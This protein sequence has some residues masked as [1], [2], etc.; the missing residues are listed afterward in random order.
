MWTWRLQNQGWGLAAYVKFNFPHCAR[1]VTIL[2]PPKTSAPHRP[3]RRD[4]LSHAP[5]ATSHTPRPPRTT[6][7][8]A[9]HTPI[10]RPTHSGATASGPRSPLLLPPHSGST[11]CHPPFSLLPLHFPPW[12]DHIHSWREGERTVAILAMGVWTAC[13]DFVAKTAPAARIPSLQ[14]FVHPWRSQ[15]ARVKSSLRRRHLQSMTASLPMV[16]VLGV[17]TINVLRPA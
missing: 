5:H 14:V 12:G 4:R 8:T 6:S 2:R 11:A 10:P 9:S 1:H 15:A 13:K 7:H 3:Q 17:K 16:S